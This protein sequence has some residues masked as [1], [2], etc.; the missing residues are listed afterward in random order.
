MDSART[1]QAYKNK[2]SICPNMI[3]FSSFY[4][5][6]N[7][8]GKGWCCFIIEQKVKHIFIDIFLQT[9]A[10]EGISSYVQGNIVHT[11]RFSSQHCSRNTNYHSPQ[12]NLKFS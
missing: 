4:H 5:P 11:K 1:M 10:C 3:T 9:E 7:R 2:D 6:T 8:M 12:K